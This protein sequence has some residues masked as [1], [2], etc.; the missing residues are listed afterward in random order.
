MTAESTHIKLEHIG[1]RLRHKREALGLSIG[2]IAEMTHLRPDYLR[3]IEILNIADLPSIGYVL[4]FVRSYAKALGMD[5][6]NAV[7]DYK[8]DVAAPE[9][10]G[11][12]DEPHFVPK[13]KIQLPKGFVPALMTVGFAV[14]MGVWYGV[15][16]ETLAAG[17]DIPEYSAHDVQSVALP[18]TDEK[19]V[20]LRA[21]APSWVQVKDASGTVLV[22]R[23]FVKG[24]TWQGPKDSG[25]RISVRDAGAIEVF[26]GDINRGVLGV[27]GQAR[28][29]IEIKQSLSD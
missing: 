17:E 2:E 15:Q 21:I 8:L 14:M 7:A 29:N 13:R 19:L 20:T 18:I 9:N 5:S 27:R 16:T 22:S 28:D 12:R 4:G 23:I 3:N 26:Y 24:E 1:T 6:N 11:M 25:Y 10:L